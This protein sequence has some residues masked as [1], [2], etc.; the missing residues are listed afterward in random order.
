MCLQE[1]DLKAMIRSG[2]KH[3]ALTGIPHLTNM[4]SFVTLLRKLYSELPSI[5][6]ILKVERI[7]NVEV[8]WQYLTEEEIDQWKRL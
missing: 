7:K 1:N 5:N 6:P 2:P 4:I 8:S 3:C